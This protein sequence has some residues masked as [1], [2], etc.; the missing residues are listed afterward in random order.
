MILKSFRM[1]DY[2]DVKPQD[3]RPGGSV[4]VRGNGKRIHVP[5]LE[6]VSVANK[7][8]DLYE[9]ARFITLATKPSEV[10]DIAVVVKHHGGEAGRPILDLPFSVCVFEMLDKPIVAWNTDGGKRLVLALLC[11]EI[12]PGQYEYFSLEGVTESLEKGDI[13]VGMGYLPANT[14]DDVLFEY[15]ALVRE[16]VDELKAGDTV[17][18]T[19]RQKHHVKIGHGPERRNHKI[20]EIVYV[21]KHKF[22]AGTGLV[23]GKEVDWTHRWEVR[24]HWRKITGI[25]K[26][27]EGQYCVNG[28]TW[29]VPHE[30]GPDDK[31]VV[32]KQRLVKNEL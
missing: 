31:P 28:L 14:D 4:F 5:R 21:T 10:K 16:M 22:K 6:Q 27:R 30:K 8:A 29:V 18:G 17:I 20:R 2:A 7:F 13:T 1:P 9:Q 26:D 11:H 3:L 32:R 15:H 23:L 19:V 24:G 25:G 12:E